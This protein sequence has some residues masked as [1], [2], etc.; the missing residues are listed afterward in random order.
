MILSR[1]GSESELFVVFLQMI[2]AL[3]ANLVAAQLFGQLT[4]NVEQQFAQLLAT[5]VGVD[6]QILDAS[7][8]TRSANELLLVDERERRHE[9]R[10]G[11]VLDHANE[12]GVRRRAHLIETSLELLDAYLAYFGELRQEVHVAARVIVASQWSE[13]QIVTQ[14]YGRF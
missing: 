4:H 1:L 3:E 13:Y 8:S 10:L 14:I 2:L 7:A 5:I 6:D 9:L 12:V 11:R